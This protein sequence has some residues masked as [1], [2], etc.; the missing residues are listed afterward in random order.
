MLRWSS[1]AS[2]RRVASLHCR[3]DNPTAAV[4]EHGTVWGDEGKAA[5][6]HHLITGGFVVCELRYSA[7]S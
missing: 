2:V 7:P 1:W 6:A 5:G 4:Q 3:F